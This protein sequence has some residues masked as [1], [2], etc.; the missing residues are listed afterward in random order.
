[1]TKRILFVDD[2][3]MVLNGLRR[4]FRPLS[5]EWVAE[6]VA[7]GAEAL[8]AIN[9]EPFDAVVTDMRMPGM[10]GAQLL[11]EVRLR[12]PQTIRMVLSGQSDQETV[13]R[14]ISPTHQYI[15]KPCDT[16]ELKSKI[17]SAFALRD[18][19]DNAELRALV[20]QQ[21]SIPSLPLPYLQ[22]MEEIN[23]K[24]PSLVRM[25]QIISQDLGMTA[26][27]LQIVN[28]AFFGLRSR[29][30]TAR[31]AVELLGMDIVK[32][33]VLSVHV[34]SQFETDCFREA[35][36]LW[37][38]A[39]SFQTGMFARLIAQRQ[40]AEHAVIEASFTAGL[41]HDIGKLILAT[42]ARKK[43]TEVLRLVDFDDVGLC[44]AE[45]TVL[46]CT[47]AEVGAYLLGV[48]GLPGPIVE[49]VAWHR[50]P[51]ASRVTV[52]SPLAAVHAAS[53]YHQ[54]WYPSRLQDAAVLDLPF[55]TALG[56]ADQEPQWKLACKALD[57]KGAMH[58]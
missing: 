19:L 37:L 16:D 40:N 46:G 48:W 49:A 22:I 41:L 27:I 2:E 21:K 9:R 10:D 44:D 4:S 54:E 55:L 51:S 20:S 34:F 42:A 23:S 52:F 33:I 35:D 32:A 13:L 11:D 17:A 8:E 7:S 18:L 56:L 31:H 29:I 57:E 43:Y 6:F 26:K 45:L 12:S 3:P 24:D 50:N 58:V 53:M 28:S 47:H 5:P 25:G 38:R 15:S 39:H 1:M 14:S 36:M 30:S